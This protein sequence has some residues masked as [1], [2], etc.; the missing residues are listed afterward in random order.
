M[1][2]SLGRAFIV[3]LLILMVFSFLFYIIGYS[4]LGI[5]DHAFTRVT[6]HPSHFV[7]WIT[8]PF[9]RLPWEWITEITEVITAD[10]IKVMYTGFIVSFVLAAIIAGF[11]GGDFSNSLGGWLLTSLVCIVL[12]IAVAFIDSYNIDWICNGYLC[13]LDYTVVKILVV[14][15]INLLIFGGITLLTVLVIGDYDKK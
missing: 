14:G 4:M 11:F 9:T 7:L 3:S 13:A 2:K 6:D 12:L 8:Y 1:E 15:L 10:G 5:L